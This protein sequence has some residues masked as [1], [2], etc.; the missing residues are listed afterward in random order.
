MQHVLNNI[1]FIGLLKFIYIFFFISCNKD[2][3]RIFLNATSIKIT[4]INMQNVKTNFNQKLKLLNLKR[5]L[6]R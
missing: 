2:P 6:I 4:Y 1:K 5:N 3:H